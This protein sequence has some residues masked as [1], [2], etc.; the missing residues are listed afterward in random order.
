MGK[1]PH[2]MGNVTFVPA[3]CDVSVFYEVP[4]YKIAI[5]ELLVSVILRK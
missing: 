5:T 4:K 2:L 3:M 1:I